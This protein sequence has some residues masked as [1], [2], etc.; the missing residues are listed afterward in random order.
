MNWKDR[1][2]FSGQERGILS[3]MTPVEMTHGG[4]TPYPQ[5]YQT[6]GLVGTELF[7]EGD[8]DINNALND[9][10]TTT[11]PEVPEMP[12][13]PVGP[14]TEVEEAVETGPIDEDY[15]S[16]VVELKQVF[17]NEIKEFVTTTQDVAEIDG[18][19]KEMNMV[20][21]DQ[22]TQL[23]KRFKIKIFSPEEDLLDPVFMQELEQLISMGSSMPI[24]D[25]DEIPGY[26]NGGLIEVIK[27]IQTQAD[28][29]EYGVKGLPLEV[30]KG[31]KTEQQTAWILDGLQKKQFEAENNPESAGSSNRAL[32]E[33]RIN[34]AKKIGQAV[35]SNYRSS[36]SRASHYRDASNAGKLAELEALDDIYK[37]A[38]T[39]S[40]RAGGT[41][42]KWDTPHAVKEAQVGLGGP[43]KKII[44]PWKLEDDLYQS[45]ASNR[46]VK[47]PRLAAQLRMIEGGQ[48]PA[49]FAAQQSYGGITFTLATW[50][51][52]AQNKLRKNF[53]K[54]FLEDSGEL[55]YKAQP[56]R[57]HG[58][59][60]TLYMLEMEKLL[61]KWQRGKEALAEA[62]K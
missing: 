62:L 26:K 23:K 46:N 22:L 52:A 16:T 59:Y 15:Q 7:E 45:F 36:G 28:L 8:E 41:G 18:F 55:Y 20:Y 57:K 4:M 58:T 10:A 30:F 53:A 5:E 37:D 14:L 2:I 25:S 11:N 54:D 29:E 51:E 13:M 50:L 17:Q 39:A 60:N 38:T 27:N 44:D 56:V 12:G 34:N 35:R 1:R 61:Q 48:T 21:S 24:N 42:G 47:Y 32:L 31:M 9:M 43:K 6:G 33:R 19:I 49:G 3:G 40:T